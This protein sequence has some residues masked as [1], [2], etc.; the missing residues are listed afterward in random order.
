VDEPIPL[1]QASARMILEAFET[2]Q[3]EFKVIT[4][5]AKGCFEQ[6]DWRAARLDAIERLELYKKVTNLI[7]SQLQEVLCSDCKNIALWSETKADY[8]RLIACKDDFE[9]AETFFNSVTRRIFTTIGVDDRIEFVD[10]D[11]EAVA[12]RSGDTSEQPVFT[13]L[14]VNESDPDLPGTV[15]EI[16]AAHPFSNGYQDIDR[17]TR[18]VSAEMI[19][20]L[21]V[22]VIQTDIHRIEMLRSV[23]YR[24]N[25]AFLIGRIILHSGSEKQILPLA[26]S[27][28]SSSSGIRVDAVLLDEDDVSIVFSF[29]HSYFHVEVEKPYELVHFLKSIIPLKRIAELY[30]SIGYNKHG[31]TELY[32][33]LMHH[34]ASSVDKFEIARGEKGMVMAVF[35]LPSYDVVFKVI[36][37]RVTP[38]KATSRTEVIERYDLVFKHD[39]VGRLVDA[40]EFE[41]LRFERER[42]TGELLVELLENAPSVVSLEDNCVVLKHLYTERRL[43]PLNLYI[44]ESPESA[45]ANAVVDYGQAI[46][47]LAAANVFPGDVLLKNFGVTRHGR[48]VF[49]DYDELCLVTECKFR[50]MPQA[51]DFDD[52][53]AV[54]PWFYVSPMDIFP[55][56]FRTFLGLTEPLRSIFIETHSDLFGIDFWRR[57][58]ARHAAGEIVETYPY[59]PS[60]HLKAP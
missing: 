2:Y 59:P 11:F 6:R 34:M 12:A 22:P 8:S 43:T 27:L 28:V 60:K 54:E 41:Y 53:F 3:S 24:D 52:E 7:V 4:Q 39:R 50:T 32:H 57:L 1:P 31:K 56:E 18:L 5:R 21:P 45:A 29:A 36:K 16:L 9:L 42:F 55:E 23:F 30:I 20:H 33:D 13:T 17:D 38:P 19:A 49:Y 37:D 10:M 47:D 40:Q 25:Y 48:V 35:T 14:V 51:R 44:K 26:I 46:K 58:Q 15:R